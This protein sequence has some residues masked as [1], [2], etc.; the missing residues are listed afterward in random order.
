MYSC[1]TR[2]E[3]VFVIAVVP[4]RVKASRVGV[5]WSGVQIDNVCSNNN[6]LTVLINILQKSEVYRG[7]CSSHQNMCTEFSR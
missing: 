5:T 2:Q 1:G 3:K 7:Y 6:V 4:R